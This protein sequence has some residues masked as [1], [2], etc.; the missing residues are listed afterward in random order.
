L[1]GLNALAYRPEYFRTLN[2]G[3]TKYARTETADR[4]E[5]GKILRHGG[6]Q[7]ACG[8]NVLSR[9]R[10]DGVRR[11]GGVSETGHQREPAGLRQERTDETGKSFS[12]VLKRVLPPLCERAGGYCQVT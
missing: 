3:R 6:F 7:V 11:H 12:A 2:A 5:A 4:G 1:G 9:Q 10:A 8:E